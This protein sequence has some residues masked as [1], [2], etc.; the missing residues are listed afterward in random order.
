M[1]AKERQRERPRKERISTKGERKRKQWLKR[2][3]ERERERALEEGRK[4]THPQMHYNREEK[5]SFKAKERDKN[6]LI[7]LY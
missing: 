2:E 4:R 7:N 3:R 5:E 6:L 1:M